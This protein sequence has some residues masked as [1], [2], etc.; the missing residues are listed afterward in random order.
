[1]LAEDIKP[2]RLKLSALVLEKVLS[3]LPNLYIGLFTF[4]HDGQIQVPPTLDKSSVI[5]LIQEISPSMTTSSG[6]DFNE[7][8][9]SLSLYL[10]KRKNQL[11]EQNETLP[12]SQV[13][14]ISDGETHEKL[15]DSTL[16]T[17]RK[18]KVPIHTLAVGTALGGRIPI[19]NTS[20]VESN[21]FDAPYLRDEKGGFAITKMDPTTLQRISTYTGGSFYTASSNQW[22]PLTSVL[23]QRIEQQ[24]SWGRLAPSFQVKR[25][26]FPELILASAAF[27]TLYLL[28]SPWQLLFASLAFMISLNAHALPKEESKLTAKEAYNLSIEKS[29]KG[30]WMEAIEL[31]Q[32]AYTKDPDPKLRKQILYNLGNGYLRFEEPGQA[33][34]AY[35]EARDIDAGGNSWKSKLNQDISDNLVLAHKLEKEIEER[36]KQEQSNP[37]QDPKD[38]KGKPNEDPGGSK[39]NYKPQEFSE[40]DKQKLWNLIRSQEQQI[41]ER[42][43]QKKNPAISQKGKPW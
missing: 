28:F 19:Q 40:A 34:Q 36:M 23:K 33:I 9:K 5:E 12:A 7:A 1:M 43:A 6:T 41:R 38:G 22:M 18:F 32:E 2:S 31:L 29:Q 20:I 11:E 39:K 10:Q 15:D 4:S 42:A 21:V 13:L 27:M 26:F 24:A 14:L 30:L 25:E 3:F 37:N 16:E 8:L 35:Q 17:F